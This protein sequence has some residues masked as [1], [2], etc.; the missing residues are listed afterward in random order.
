MSNK[1]GP[2]SAVE[3]YVHLGPN[4]TAVPL[5]VT[6]TFW[7]K[8]T[9]GAFSNLGPGRLVSTYDFKGDWTSW[10]KHPAGEE[11]VI[12]LAGAMDL[13][14]SM[15]GREESVSLTS[16]GQ[17]LIVPRDIW[18]TANVQKEALAMFITDGEGTEHRPRV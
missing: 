15:D 14:L 17:Y 8:L 10:E 7:E 13:V 11:L 12:L 9:T 3:T 6:S 4:G 16:P 2:Y 1:V 5:Q 18:H